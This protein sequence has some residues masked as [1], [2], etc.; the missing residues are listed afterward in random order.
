MEYYR[1]R[2]AFV[3]G[4]VSRG[5]SLTVWWRV[6]GDADG[7]V[8]AIGEPVGGGEGER[9]QCSRF[10]KFE[11]QA[12]RRSDGQNGSGPADGVRWGCEKR[13]EEEFGGECVARGS[14]DDGD[15][16]LV[17]EVCEGGSDG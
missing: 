7:K 17:V 16:A 2:V 15:F 11:L 9:R 10:L 12:E 1:R 6:G 5:G 8:V 4:P 13:L 3:A 14:E